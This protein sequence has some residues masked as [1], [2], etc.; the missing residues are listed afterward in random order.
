MLRLFAPTLAR[1]KCNLLL[2]S[3]FV[4]FIICSMTKK[5]KISF[6]QQHQN[7]S[8]NTLIDQLK[9]ST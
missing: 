9:I 6:F 8:I 5:S 4:E 1:K 7:N 3:L 2:I